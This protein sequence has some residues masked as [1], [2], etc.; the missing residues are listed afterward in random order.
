[1]YFLRE[2]QI[3]VWVVCSG[4][5][6]P[7]ISG[8]LLKCSLLEQTIF[9]WPSSESGEQGEYEHTNEFWGEYAFL[10]IDSSGYMGPRMLANAHDSFKG[11]YQTYLA[12]SV[13]KWAGHWAVLK[14]T[15]SRHILSCHVP[16]RGADLILMKQGTTAARLDPSF[17]PTPSPSRCPQFDN[18]GINWIEAI[19]TCLDILLIIFSAEKCVRKLFLRQKK[20]A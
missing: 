5:I 11:A 16:K 15:H 19:I 6:P 1:M 7:Y 8:G 9:C 2:D 14:T 12:D 4:L 17:C 18:C 3:M 10:L 13:S 20:C